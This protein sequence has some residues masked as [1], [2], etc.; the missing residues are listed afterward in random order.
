MPQAEWSG[1]SFSMRPISPTVGLNP[2][3]RTLN[4]VLGADGSLD[5]RRDFG[6]NPGTAPQN[7]I[8]AEL[9][10]IVYLIVKDAAQIKWSTGG[11]F[12]AIVMA[13]TDPPINAGVA[14][15]AE[16]GSF[17]QHADEIYYCD[18]NTIFAWDGANLGRRPGIVGLQG[19]TYNGAGSELLPGGPFGLS[20]AAYNAVPS[21]NPKASAGMDPGI[22]GPEQVSISQLGLLK[23]G[24]KTLNTAFAFSYYDIKRRIYGRRS[25]SFAFPYIYGPPDPDGSNQ[26]L[27]DQRSQFAKQVKTPTAPSS[28]P[29]YLIAIWFSLGQNVLT[30]EQSTVLSF[31]FL[32]FHEHAPS[33]SKRMTGTLF[34]EKIVAAGI[35]GVLCVKDNATLVQ[36]G[37]YIDI[38]ER[39][40]P[41]RFMAVLSN[42]TAIY[43]FPWTA[44]PENG[45]SAASIGQHALYSVRHPEQVGL[46]TENQR[47]TVS[48][49][50]N[51]KGQPRIVFSDGN[52]QLLLTTQA[53]YSIGFD[54]NVL[55]RELTSVPGLRSISSFTSSSIGNLW[56]ADEGVILFSGSRRVL[57]DEK[58]GFAQW[59]QD[60]N[61]TQRSQVVIG[62]ADS[63]HQILVVSD[64]LTPGE[65]GKH[66]LCWDY[67][68]EFTSE[69]TGIGAPTYCV[70]FRGA[71]P[72]LFLF[73]GGTYPGIGY[74]SS[75]ASVTLWINDSINTPKNLGIITLDCGA[76]TGDVTISVTA[77]DTGD[78]A[79]LTAVSTV[80]KTQTKTVGAGRWTFEEF[81]GMRARLFKIKI[82]VHSGNGRNSIQ[83]V[84]AEYDFVEGDDAISD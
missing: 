33:M 27:T 54:G 78:E 51:L 56:F 45:G 63:M 25:E 48:L 46:G 7:H 67:E 9:G 76:Q 14:A 53:A 72:S 13:V 37:R 38:Y 31:P 10:G 62:A 55:L 49:L 57:L 8:V 5:K 26:I 42:G 61:A 70:F 74:T 47:D 23:A 36:S 60:L 40:V 24:E 2:V 1:K 64:N 84:R 32:F 43:F 12:T 30:N 21:P 83:R 66:A 59:Y 20:D 73:G 69:F 75:E 29:E 44:T 17:V 3:T 52:T 71:V 35:T 22:I 11:A 6:A 81:L 77:H 80:P 39:P 16:R 68:R 18:T 41:A 28:H 82:T 15:V 58:L 79:D 34:L 50:P 19:K 65:S 4:M